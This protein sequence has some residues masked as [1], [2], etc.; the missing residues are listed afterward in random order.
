MQ[1]ILKYFEKLFQKTKIFQD[2]ESIKINQGRL[3]KNVLNKGNLSSDIR[4]YEI[5]IFSQWGEDGIIQHLIEHIDIKNK[6]FIE[7]GVENFSESNCRFLM[8]N[9][10][11]SGFVIDGNKNNIKDLKS[12]YYFWKY[13]LT[14][15]SEFI[16]KEN[17]NDLLDISNFDKDLGILSIDIDGNDYYILDAIK[18]YKPRILI[19]EFNSN[20]DFNE[21]ISVPYDKNFYRFDKCSS[22]IYWGASLKAFIYL[23]A[24]KGYKFIGTNTSACNAF[25]VKNEFVPDHLKNIDE[26]SFYNNSKYRETRDKNGKLNYLNFEERKNVLKGLEFFNVIKKTNHKFK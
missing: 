5:K 3:L 2:I 10:N 24:K 8:M 26:E 7:F 11:W 17:I 18:K 19:T 12:S 20:F 4:D 16:T 13:E 22:G 25:F 15:I 1:K 6:T 21:A 14:A 23:A 9:N